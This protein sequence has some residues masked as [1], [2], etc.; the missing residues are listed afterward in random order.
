MCFGHFGG[1]LFEAGKVYLVMV[2]FT[3]MQPDLADSLDFTSPAQPVWNIV[4][5]HIL[6]LM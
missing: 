3:E 2:I 4:F 1:N 5:G 6:L